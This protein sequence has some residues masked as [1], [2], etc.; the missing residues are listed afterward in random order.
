[1]RRTIFILNCDLIQSGILLQ[2]YANTQL[3][4]FTDS[5]SNK[6]RQ[7]IYNYIRAQSHRGGP[8]I[9]VPVAPELL[10]LQA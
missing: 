10:G 3:L 5:I 9:Q 6:K 8:C 2:S 1:M 7:N 4:L